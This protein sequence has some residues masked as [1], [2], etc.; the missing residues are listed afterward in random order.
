M[1]QYNYEAIV[2]KLIDREE[3]NYDLCHMLSDQSFSFL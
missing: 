2:P 1:I 3:K